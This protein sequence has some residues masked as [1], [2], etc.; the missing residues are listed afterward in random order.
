MVTEQSGGLIQPQFHQ[1]APGTWVD[2]VR[3]T[4]RFPGIPGQGVSPLSQTLSQFWL[5][6]VDRFGQAIGQLFGQVS[7]GQQEAEGAYGL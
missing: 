3:I 6:F 4:G 2:A 5:T 1:V 7:A